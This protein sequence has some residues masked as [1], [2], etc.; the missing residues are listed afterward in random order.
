MSKLEYVK[1]YLKHGLTP[2]PLHNIKPNGC[3]CEKGEACTS[4]GKH[5]RVKR[6]TAIVATEQKWVSWLRSWPDMNIGVLTGPETG[7]MVLDV[8]PRHG[9]DESLQKLIAA[10]GDLPTTVSA[11]TGGGG[12]HYLFRIPEGVRVSNSAGDIAPGIDIRGDGGL[13]VVAPSTTKGEYSWN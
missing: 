13:I 8:D 10:H 2:V 5:P 7:V 9:G 11:A 1:H 4:A 6:Q 3:S 12:S